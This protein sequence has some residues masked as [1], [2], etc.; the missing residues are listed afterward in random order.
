MA[1]DGAKP[2]LLRQIL[3]G[4]VVGVTIA[5]I[6]GGYDR[7]SDTIERRDQERHIGEFLSAYLC[8]IHTAS[9]RYKEDKLLIMKMG[10]YQSMIDRLRDVLDD[11]STKMTYDRRDK[12]WRA[13]LLFF[14]EDRISRI[15]TSYE[16]VDNLRL[17]MIVESLRD[18]EWRGFK[19]TSL[20]ECL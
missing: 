12:A 16:E 11:R 5:V 4:V 10:L 14:D 3:H 8:D 13:M 1:D 18:V 6:L 20:E 19:L 17:D 9:E 15:P 7:V 2:S